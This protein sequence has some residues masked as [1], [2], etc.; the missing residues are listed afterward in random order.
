MLVKSPNKPD[1]CQL[2]AKGSSL[3]LP[4]PVDSTHFFA[5]DPVLTVQLENSDGARWAMGFAESQ[6]KKNTPARY[7]AKH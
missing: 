3:L 5:S 2:K 1:K 6:A 4:T 7:Q